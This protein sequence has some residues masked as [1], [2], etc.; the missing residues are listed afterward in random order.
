LFIRWLDEYVY[1]EDAGYITV[2]FV[3]LRL[4]LRVINEA[5]VPPQWVIITAIAIILAWGF[6][7]RTAPENLE[8][9]EE[10]NEGVGSEKLEITNEELRINKELSNPSTSTPSPETT[11]S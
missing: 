5:L 1:L 2:A 8:N 11:N 10:T 9:S 7:K 3:G 4:L 6:S